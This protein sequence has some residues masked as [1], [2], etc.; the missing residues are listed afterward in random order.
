MSLIGTSPEYREYASR[1]TQQAAPVR[2]FAPCSR[3]VPMDPSCAT[4]EHS[5]DNPPCA[6]LCAAFDL[7][8]E[9]RTGGGPETM[10]PHIPDPSPGPAA[11]TEES[12]R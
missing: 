8:D 3:Y 11:A 1:M 6:D 9:P 10:Q 12:E 2:P 7:A 4:C 5:C